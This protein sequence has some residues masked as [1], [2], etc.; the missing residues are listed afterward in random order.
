MDIFERLK[1]IKAKSEQ[2]EAGAKADPAMF[3]ARGTAPEQ[4]SGPANPPASKLVGGRIG[5][6]GKPAGQSGR[7]AH[8]DAAPVEPVEPARPAPEP[9]PGPVEPRP[10]PASAA[11]PKAAGPRILRPASAQ[12]S[13][14]PVL[15]A[16]PSAA[17]KP[18][19]RPITA[20]TA[21]PAPV[22][23][24]EDDDELDADTISAF[25]SGMSSYDEPAESA[26]SHPPLDS[27]PKAPQA[28]APAEPAA[29]AAP[30]KRAIL[31]AT[32]ALARIKSGVQSRSEQRAAT[33]AVSA[34]GLVCANSEPVYS[35]DQFIEDWP[36][37]EGME[38][39]EPGA[40]EEYHGAAAEVIQKGC[41]RINQLFAEHLDG[42]T[43]V[44]A[45]EPVIR[46]IGAIVKLTFLRVK[47][48]P[49]AY[50]MLDLTDRATLIKGLRAMTAKR[51]ASAQM[52]APNDAKSHSAA[53]EQMVQADSSLK[54][55]M[56]GMDFNIDLSSL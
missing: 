18:G 31:P 14:R 51:H 30:A 44:R 23:P 24:D 5:R 50:D 25:M 3:P 29:P 41:A 32:S 54:D 20:K 22:E 38:E 48:A 10:A 33:P 56:G 45:P 35:P 15:S 8:V 7:A 47:E 40:A 27:A 42:L 26:E 55:L 17:A 12:L 36:S 49:G 34:D 43:V 46:E 2:K 1:A 39:W 21:E 16:A 6:I 9:Q 4:T 37:V 11:E 19:L 53:L 28:E 52:R 13:R